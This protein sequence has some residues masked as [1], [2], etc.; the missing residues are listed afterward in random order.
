MDR[1]TIRLYLAI[2][3]VFLVL[4]VI[5]WDRLSR[6]KKK[7]V[8]LPANDTAEYNDSEF[9]PVSMDTLETGEAESD[10]PSLYAGP[11]PE[12]E[13]EDLLEIDP[14]TEESVRESGVADTAQETPE[15]IQLYVVAAEEFSFPGSTLVEALSACGMT[16]GEMD[17]FHH[18][19][20]A[21]GLPLYSAVNMVEPGTF[22]MDELES[23]ITPG[24]AF[25]LQV[26]LVDRP[27]E[28]LDE[29]ISTAR[30]LAARLGGRVLDDSQSELSLEKIRML[31]ESLGQPG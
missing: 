9:T 8:D 11:D 23:F 29:M 21:G 25:F 18:D 22:P 2:A 7:P 3:G 16:F 13:A 15:L 31:R 6:R 30:T 28:A 24:V 20:D 5:V 10:L 19:T 14:L 26:P 4:G 17:I 12:T 27:L 1:D